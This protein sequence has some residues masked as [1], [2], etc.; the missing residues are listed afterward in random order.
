[1]LLREKEWIILTHK[2][3][4]GD[5]LGAGFGLAAVLQSLGKEVQV[6]GE[7]PFPSKFSYLYQQVP[8]KKKELPHAHIVAVDVADR[9]LLGHAISKKYPQIDLCIDHHLH[10]RLGAEQNYI[11]PS[12][13][14]ACELVFA[15]AEAMETPIPKS[16]A[17]CFY[18]GICTDTGCFVFSNTTKSAHMAAARLIDLGA[19]VSSINE[20]LFQVK[21][22][23]R[24]SLERLVLDR[25]EFLEDGRCALVVVT[26]RM[27]E[28]AHATESDFDGI[29]A[30]S[31]G[32]EGVQV[33]VT[34]RE[35]EEQ[36]K[37]SVRTDSS[38]SAADIC[39]HFGGGGHARAAGCTMQG[40][41]QE[42]KEKIM[43][44][45]RIRL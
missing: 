23:A 28:E 8:L 6:V 11:Y 17:D 19:E 39:R 20:R 40:A 24:L 45:I 37:I 30:I 3:P 41:L 44:Q 15:V 38:V 1:M 33:G 29:P 10:N 35:K 32:I 9:A 36:Y 31:R 34:I 2:N 26:R 4:D 25:M 21:S 27:M 12:V 43:A 14:S 18:T 42:I 16:A 13:S 7:A 22:R 5:T